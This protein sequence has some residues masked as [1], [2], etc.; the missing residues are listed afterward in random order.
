MKLRI[1]VFN[2]TQVMTA[3]LPQA[4]NIAE[5]FG[6][7]MEICC[8]SSPVRIAQRSGLAAG[9]YRPNHRI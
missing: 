3:F 6:C 8:I 1:S 7:E 2:K 9:S 4:L 5:L